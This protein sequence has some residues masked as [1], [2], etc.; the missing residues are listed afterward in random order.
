MIKEKFLTFSSKRIYEQTLPEI[1]PESLSFVLEKGN[2]AL[3]VYNT[4]FDFVPG[5]G[6]SGQVLKRGDGYVYWDDLNSVKQGI[7]VNNLG[8]IYSLYIIKLSATSA[9]TTQEIK[10]LGTFVKG[11]EVTLYI[12]KDENSAYAPT[13]TLDPESYVSLNGEYSFDVTDSW[14]KMHF[15]SDGS[16]VYV[17]SSAKTIGNLQFIEG[18]ND[19]DVDKTYPDALMV[20]NGTTEAKNPYEYSGG[21]YNASKRTTG[22]KFGVDNTLFSIG[23]G[24]NSNNRHNAFSIYQDGRIGIPDVNSSGEY[25]EKEEIILQDRLL[26]EGGNINQTLVK[27]SN[28]TGWGYC[29]WVG[30][31]DEY[32]KISSKDSNTLYFVK[33]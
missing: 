23:N 6:V 32:D 19:K 17:E 11:Q 13:I 8:T 10:F 33:E 21:L 5:N 15:V 9:D 28:G 27:T 3:H 14:I 25:Y 12:T 16:K 18:A 22:T 26:P 20:N 4:K 1:D 31:Q 29:F 24:L 30:S 2:E 7:A